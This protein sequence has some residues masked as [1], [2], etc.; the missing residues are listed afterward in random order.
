MLIVRNSFVEYRTTPPA[1][2]AEVRTYGG[3]HNSRHWPAAI[4]FCSVKFTTADPLNHVRPEESNGLKRCVGP[5]RAANVGSF[6]ALTCTVV[7]RVSI[8]AVWIFTD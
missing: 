5:R 8:N 7:G 3:L 1:I 6:G 4:C 2:T